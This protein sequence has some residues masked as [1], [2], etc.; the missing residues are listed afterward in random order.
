MYSPT[1]ESKRASTVLRS[2]HNS[3]HPHQKQA[4]APVF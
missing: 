4:D 2:C 3:D 1:K